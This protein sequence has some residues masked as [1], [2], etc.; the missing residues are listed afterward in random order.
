MKSSG[1]RPAKADRSGRLRPPPGPTIDSTMLRPSFPSSVTC[2]TQ[3]STT[4]PTS[5]PTCLSGLMSEASTVSSSSPS[6]SHSM[7]KVPS[8]F[9]TFTVAGYHSISSLKSAETRSPSPNPPAFGSGFGILLT[10]T[11]PSRAAPQST[12]APNSLTDVTL[13]LSFCPISSSSSSSL[14]TTFRMAPGL[15]VASE[16]SSSQTRVKVSSPLSVWMMPRYHSPSSSLIASTI[17]PAT[18]GPSR[19]TSESFLRM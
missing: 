10:W 19:S 6:S 18:N 12:K 8:L 13:P 5:T 9:A 1:F 17:S 15:T 14:G 2:E 11:R 16:A 7:L 4:W 3:T